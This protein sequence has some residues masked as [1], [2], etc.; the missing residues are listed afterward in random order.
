VR[1]RGSGQVGR[2]RTRLCPDGAAPGIDTD[3]LHFREVNDDAVVNRSESREAMATAAHRKREISGAREFD[4]AEDVGRIRGTHDE[5][6]PAIKERILYLPRFVIVRIVWANQ[7]AQEP[8]FKRGNA[9]IR[10]SSGRGSR[11]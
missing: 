1:L 7:S 6:W 11:C 8:R 9:Y 10:Y 4:R 5:V 3:G 2:R